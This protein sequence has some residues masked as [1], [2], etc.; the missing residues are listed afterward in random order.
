MLRAGL[1]QLL[2][3]AVTAAAVSAS[4]IGASAYTMPTPG[5][6]TLFATRSTS[7][8]GGA[9]TLT[10][11]FTDTRGNPIQHMLVIFSVV[12]APPDAPPHFLSN[13]A[14]TDGT[15]AASV[16]VILPPGCEGKYYRFRATSGSG[17]VVHIGV[18]GTLVPAY[19]NTSAPR[20][21]NIPMLA[22]AAVLALAAA[23]M[24]GLA[25]RS[26]GRRFRLDWLPR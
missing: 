15:G 12:Q 4:S 9:I 25:A 26:L 24:G 3:A 23:V 14:Y 17:Q 7:A 10:A 11:R 21:F 6:P 5:V 8:C 2:A 18:N 20:S 1:R 22:F 16:Q 13:T 19:P